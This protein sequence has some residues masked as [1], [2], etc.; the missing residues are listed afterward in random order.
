VGDSLVRD[1][2]MAKAAGVHAVWARYG[3]QYDRA[4][5]EILVRVTHWT[6][7][8]VRREEELRR[9]TKDV[10]PDYTI[11]D[12]GELLALIGIANISEEIRVAR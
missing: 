8:D 12:F 2:S 3:L 4:L 7:E 10:Q 5:W 11:D 9:L 1:V 6:D